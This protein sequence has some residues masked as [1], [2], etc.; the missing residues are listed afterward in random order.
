MT[1]SCPCHHPDGYRCSLRRAHP[2][3]CRRVVTTYPLPWLPSREVLTWPSV[4]LLDMPA[5][6]TR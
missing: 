1:D 4:R 3:S 2:G 5:E 6:E